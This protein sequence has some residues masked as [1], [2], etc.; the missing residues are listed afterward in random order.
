MYTDFQGI[1]MRTGAYFCIVHPAEGAALRRNLLFILHTVDF[2]D[3][4]GIAIL[5]AVARKAG[6][7]PRLVWFNKKTIHEVFRET[8][9]DVVCYSAMSSDAEL[10]LA[11][12]NYLKASYSF[13]SIMGG[14]HPTFFPEVIE[15]PGLDYICRGEGELA[16]AEFLD[17]LARG[18]SPDGVANIGTKQAINPLR[19][20]IA[21]LDA[22]PLPD[23][24]LMFDASELRYSPLK[25]FMTSRGCPFSCSYC[26]NNALKQEYKGLGS[27][28]R[29][30][31]V[32]R[33]I[34]EIQQIRSKYPLAFIKFED[35][36]FAYK[37]SWLETFVKA[38]KREVNLPFN[39][40][41]RIDLCNEKRFRLLKEAGCV[42]ISLSIDSGNKRIRNEVLHRQMRLEN[43]EI[44]ARIHQIKQAGLNV[45]TST[46]LGVP[47]ATYADELAGVALNAASH[48][49]FAGAPI[50]LPFP[51]TGIWNFCND[52][53]YLSKDPE[54]SF[55]SIQKTSSLQCFTEREKAR[56]WN[57]SVFYPAI[58][59]FPLLRKPLLLLVDK[60]P[61][62]RFYA[63]VH[64]LVKAFLMSRYIYPFSGNYWNKIKW[65]GKALRIEVARMLGKQDTL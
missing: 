4:F 2:I 38:Y 9:P 60:S 26:Y 14:A 44:Q 42:S 47:T 58:V 65:L 51:R 11:I 15:R 24:G 17:C 63:V 49:D 46:I 10:Y 48:V 50:L 23:R 45:M 40:L 28:V 62:L 37:T 18:E 30:H 27:Y 54:D 39:C 3:N 57:L 52:H 59:K 19:P 13:V 20:L 43:S 61:P 22:I 64:V 41:Q 16:F 1:S 6:W 35:D 31:S 32:D 36:L 56:Q 8:A 21:D 12:N 29:L 7:N 25:T 55:G 33:V 53:G 34:T 5:S